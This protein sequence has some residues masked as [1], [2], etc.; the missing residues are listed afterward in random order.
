MNY[1]NL[2]NL[3][4][5]NKY[6][7][8]PVYSNIVYLILVL[9]GVSLFIAG[10]I[11]LIKLAQQ[12]MTHTG[13][14]EPF[15]TATKVTY[16]KELK[17]RIQK[18]KDLNEV[19]DDSIDTFSDN[20]QD[21][22]EVYAQVEEVYVGNNS[23]PAT[24][25]EYSLPK[26]ELNKRL[27]RRKELAK[28]RLK[29]ARG[30]YGASIKTTVYECFDNPSTPPEESI[31]DLEDELRS[32]LEDLE[33]KIQSV[34]IGPIGN[35]GSELNA[36]IKFNNKYIKKSLEEMGNERARL[37]EGYAAPLPPS[38]Y[39][40]LQTV[41]GIALIKRADTA[42]NNANKIVGFV[43]QQSKTVKMQKELAN[44]LTK[45]SSRLQNGNVSAADIN[46]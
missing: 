35:K 20:V 12:C 25:E 9:I 33:T 29:E 38:E 34:E 39:P 11:Y 21:T 37:I 19:L 10:V 32:E 7:S 40:P 26:E 3:N 17:D 46:V 6:I 42:I 27:E 41:S 15:T 44:E 36:L 16:L 13:Y 45:T 2:N 23:A 24:E 28:R 22:C 31:S 8:L 4:N 43:T 5:L 18:V 30:L 14:Y 1:I